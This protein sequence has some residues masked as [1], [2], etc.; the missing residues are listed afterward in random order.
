MLKH[1]N[2]KKT[3]NQTVFGALMFVN[4]VAL[5]A[6]DEDCFTVVIRVSLFFFFLLLSSDALRLRSA[7]PNATGATVNSNEFA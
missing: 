2:K 5:I 3:T 7:T 6:G 1:R 4:K